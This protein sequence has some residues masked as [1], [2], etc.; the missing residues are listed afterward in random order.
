MPLPSPITAAYG[1]LLVDAYT[2]YPATTEIPH[3]RNIRFTPSNRLQD[4]P[5]NSG[6]A[7]RMAGVYDSK[8]S[9]EIHPDD[10]AD[11]PGASLGLAVYAGISGG[12]LAAVPDVV[13]FTYDRFCRCG[14]Y[15]SSSTAS[16]IRRVPGQRDFS[17]SLAIL[18]QS[19]VLIAS[20][21]WL[22]EG[23]LIDLEI[24]RVA[25]VGFGGTFRVAN[26]D[27][28]IDPTSEE[29]IGVTVALEGDGDIEDGGEL[30]FAHSEGDYISV[31]GMSNATKGI[32][33]IFIIERIRGTVDL[34]AGRLVTLAVDCLGDGTPGIEAISL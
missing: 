32:K 29:P 9:F 23:N 1:S 18:S 22:D 14:E 6:F 26:F 20:P 5:A 15:A 11:R 21:A 25:V 30:N 10:G 7:R 24:R 3:C 31:S 8:L 4:Y 27:G 34:K 19:G 12:A 17:A 13:T 2:T 28:L 33:G 16:F